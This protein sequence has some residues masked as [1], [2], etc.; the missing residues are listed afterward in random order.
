V[1]LGLQPLWALKIFLLEGYMSKELKDYEIKI[2]D[3]YLYNQNF[4]NPTHPD[5]Q[6]KGYE[7]WAAN[8]VKEG[9]FPDIDTALAYKIGRRGPRWVEEFEHSNGKITT[10]KDQ[11]FSD[12]KVNLEN[13]KNEY[14]DE[15]NIKTKEIDDA[16]KQL[17]S[18]KKSAVKMTHLKQMT[19]IMHNQAKI[20]QLEITAQLDKDTE[21]DDAEKTKIKNA[22]AAKVAKNKADLEKLSADLSKLDDDFKTK[23]NEI[24]ELTNNL[25]NSLSSKKVEIDN[26]IANIKSISEGMLEEKI[27][28]CHSIPNYKNRQELEDEFEAQLKAESEATQT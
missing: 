11:E 25:N 6:K 3:H 8:A 18:I 23:Q 24:E 21:M 15:M 27:A 20:T 14:M 4:D 17:D 26:V 12:A 7:I 16:N 28:T 1:T 22:L 10:T 9:C 13:K 5:Y 19:Q 2:L